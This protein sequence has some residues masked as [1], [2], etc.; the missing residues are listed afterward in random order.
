MN[1]CIYEYRESISTN[2]DSSYVT[3]HLD[4]VR[5][6]CASAMNQHYL[7]YKISDS[8]SIVKLDMFGHDETTIGVWVVDVNHTAN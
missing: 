7:A 3:I 8:I 1:G 5:D 4:N 6:E 2:N